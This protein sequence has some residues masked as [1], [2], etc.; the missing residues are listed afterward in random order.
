M[1][2]VRRPLLALPGLPAVPWPGSP[3]SGP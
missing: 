3:G 2:G 1:P